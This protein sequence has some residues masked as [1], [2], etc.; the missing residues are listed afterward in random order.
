LGFITAVGLQGLSL[1]SR[2]AAA[3]G[4]WMHDHSSNFVYSIGY[5]AA[6]DQCLQAL[7]PIRRNQMLAVAFGASIVGNTWEEVDIPGVNNHSLPIFNS[8]GAKVRTDE[9]DLKSGIAG[10]IAYVVG[11]KAVETFVPGF[12]LSNYCR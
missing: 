3:Q 5:L 2:S 7:N 1:A 6:L 10:S 11:I 4:T 9:D 8:A 12:S